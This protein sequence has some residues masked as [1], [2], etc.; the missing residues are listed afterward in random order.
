MAAGA[1]NDSIVTPVTVNMRTPVTPGRSASTQR[2]M[3]EPILPATIWNQKTRGSVSTGRRSSGVT[4]KVRSS[5]SSPRTPSVTR[6]FDVARRRS[7]CRAKNR[8]MSS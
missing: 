8:S 7:V 5:P 1:V 4:V 6:P 3:S 2:A